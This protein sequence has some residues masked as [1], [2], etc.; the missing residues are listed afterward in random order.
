MGNIIS[1]LLPTFYILNARVFL[2]EVFLS[3]NKYLISTCKAEVFCSLFGEFNKHFLSVF[4]QFI[5]EKK[6]R[7]SNYKLY[8]CKGAFIA[9]FY[10]NNLVF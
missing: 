6:A 10:L 8:G 7:A 4:G 2:L 1:P 5:C 9:Y 3:A